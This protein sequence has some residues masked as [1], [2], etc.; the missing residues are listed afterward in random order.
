MLATSLEGVSF[1]KT[2]SWT[3]TFSNVVSGSANSSRAALKRVADR[4]TNVAALML[5]ANLIFFALSITGARITPDGSATNPLIRSSGISF[6]TFAVTNMIF[7]D[8]FSSRWT[9]YGVTDV[10][11][12]LYTGSFLQ[13]HLAGRTFVV[14]STNAGCLAPSSQAVL[15]KSTLALANWPAFVKTADL[16]FWTGHN[17]A[18]VHAR[19]VSVDVDL[20]DLA[21]WAIS[22][23]LAGNF[24]GAADVKVISV[25]SEAL[26]TNAVH[27]VVVRDA[28]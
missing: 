4:L 20:A 25:A 3:S 26:V 16:I 18:W 10:N 23:D 1:E 15:S 5:T 19:S 8:A 12:I 14:A 28:E 2:T 7:R 9:G 27:V 13:A 24:W 17:L 21:L 6:T 11:T 22:C